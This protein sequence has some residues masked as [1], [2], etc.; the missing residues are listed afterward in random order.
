MLGQHTREILAELGYD[1]TAID[2]LRD[3]GIVSWP[4]DGYPYTV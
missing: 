3:R 1:E 4:D 2:D